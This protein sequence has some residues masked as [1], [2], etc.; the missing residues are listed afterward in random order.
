MRNLN[1]FSFARPMRSQLKMV[2]SDLFITSL[3]YH[4]TSLGCLINWL[5]HNPTVTNLSRC[6]SLFEMALSSPHSS[7]KGMNMTGSTR[8]FKQPLSSS[9]VCNR[10][11]LDAKMSGNPQDDDYEVLAIAKEFQEQD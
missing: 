1:R 3:K 2:R 8:V 10:F 9:G 5:V 7:L 6:T 11:R 4:G